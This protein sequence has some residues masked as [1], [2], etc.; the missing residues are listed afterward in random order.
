MLLISSI[1]ISTIM[2]SEEHNP[3]SRRRTMNAIDQ[4]LPTQARVAQEN[5]RTN[6]WFEVPVRDPI[7]EE[8]RCTPRTKRD[9]DLLTEFDRWYDDE[10]EKGDAQRQLPDFPLD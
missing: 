4:T 6:P 1:D 10:M 2:G 7:A 3:L 5:F 9:Y 8:K